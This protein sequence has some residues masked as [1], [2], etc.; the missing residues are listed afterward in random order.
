MHNR[1]TSTVY[2]I[3]VQNITPINLIWN[4]DLIPKR[5]TCGNILHYA[6]SFI[7][8]DTSAAVSKQGSRTLLHFTPHT[9]NQSVSA[10]AS[11][12]CLPS[13]DQLDRSTSRISSTV[14]RCSGARST[15]QCKGKHRKV[16]FTFYPI[17]Y[18]C[19]SYLG[20]LGLQVA[21][22]THSVEELFS[23]VRGIG[24]VVIG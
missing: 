12:R 17:W 13:L 20:L 16:V 7:S 2:G 19:S 23:R 4:D 1:Y 18:R 5:V 22:I 10:S 6:F 21:C 15:E 11:L 8:H 14:Q 24:D 3:P 9:F